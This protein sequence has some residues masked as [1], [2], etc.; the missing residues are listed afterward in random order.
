MFNVTHA[1]LVPGPPVDLQCGAPPTEANT[2]YCE[3]KGAE[4]FLV[5]GKP[6]AT[7]LTGSSLSRR[8]WI[9]FV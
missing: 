3:G 7:H 5:G 2:I 4:V 6:R 9:R 1:T 8:D